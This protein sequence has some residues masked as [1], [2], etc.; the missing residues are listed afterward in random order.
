M[1]FDTHPHIN[2]LYYKLRWP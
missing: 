2:H 1:K